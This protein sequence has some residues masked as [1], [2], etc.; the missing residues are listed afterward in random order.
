MVQPTEGYRMRRIG[1]SASLA[2]GSIALVGVLLA[3]GCGQQ[4][5]ESGASSQQDV[6]TS[7]TNL[8]PQEVLV[9][10]EVVQKYFPEIDQQTTAT[11]NST[12]SGVPAATRMVIYE[13]GDGRRV[14]VSA[15]Q[16]SS[17]TSA[18]SAFEQAID[19]SE[20]VQ[21]FVAL[22]APSDVGDKAFAG[23]VTQGDETHIGYGAL[24]GEYVIGVTSAGHP[25]TAENIGKLTDLT[26][27]AV[28]K[29]ETA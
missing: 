15:D 23:A 27:E 3:G 9:G 16:Y 1:S 28:E 5:T 19:K 11:E 20:V 18:S 14:T 6:T 4:R 13:G 10:L 2:L 22:P 7:G 29:A 12:A 25:A 17:P 8:L 24:A 26:R 21:G